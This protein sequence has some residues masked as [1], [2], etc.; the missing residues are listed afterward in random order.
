MKCL[1][2]IDDLGSGG[3][4][5]QLVNLA[6]GLARRD[7]EVALFTYY[8][9]AFFQPVVDDAGIPVL[10]HRKQGRFDL[11]PIRALR[12]FVREGAFDAV[13]AFLETPAVYAELACLAAPGVRLVVG[14][15]N[16][17]PDDTVSAAR[18]IKSQLHRSAH[19]VV[20]N[21]FA[22]ADWLVRHFPYLGPTVRTVWNG[23][24]LDALRPAPELP[25]STN[26][27]LNLLGIGR[28]APQKNLGALMEAL[29][30]CRDSGLSVRLDWVGRVDDVAEESRVRAIVQ[31]RGLDE[32][33]HWLGERSDIADRLRAADALIAPSLW[34]GLP[35]VVCE[36]LACGRPVLASTVSDNYRLIGDGERGI[37]FAPHA[38]AMA[39]AIQ[40]FATLPHASKVKMGQQARQFAEAH[41]GYD[42]VVDAYEHLL[43]D[44]MAP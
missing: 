26:G 2:V 8:P 13:L 14:E 20:T 21:S 28:I 10:R 18:W 31:A 27:T 44:T 43:Q 40:S 38:N 23:V 3:A 15:R 19:C 39:E 41:L 36:A 4:Q 11:S 33:V 30:R 16:S 42:A 29:A 25:V 34:E 22:H 32:H 1:L 5:R 9:D 37:C 7:H 24:D 6:R 17:V 35:N 12:R